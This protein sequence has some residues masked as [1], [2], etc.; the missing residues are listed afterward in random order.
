MTST[1]ETREEQTNF[2]KYNPDPRPMNFFREFNYR[3]KSSG[4]HDYI[5]RLESALQ[6][7]ST[8]EKLLNLKREYDNND[9]NDDWEQYED[10][11]KD[12][13]INICFFIGLKKLKIY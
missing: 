5:L 8:S 2:L 1:I 3:K 10:W 12:K 11:K 13:K 7:D 6:D 4:Y 9:Y